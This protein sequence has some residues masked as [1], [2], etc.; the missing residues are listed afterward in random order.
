MRTIVAQATI[1]TT[2]FL[3]A[4]SAGKSCWIVLF[5]A[6]T[7][8]HYNDQD[9]ERSSTMGKRKATKPPPASSRKK[10]APTEE[11]KVPT[12][13]TP[14]EE[15]K[16]MDEECDNAAKSEA[17][18][19]KKAKE[20]PIDGKINVKK[21][22]GEG[23]S[24]VLTITLLKDFEGSGES[25]EEFDLLGL[26][27][28]SEDIYGGPASHTRRLVQKCWQ[29]L[30]EKSI[31]SYYNYL[32][33]H[34]VIPGQE[35]ATEYFAVLANKVKDGDCKMSDD[36]SDDDNSSYVSETESGDETEDSTP[37]KPTFS[38]PFS[39][40]SDPKGAKYSKSSSKKA[41]SSSKSASSSKKSKS[42]KKTKSS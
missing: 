19:K 3:L 14:L 13:T 25:R 23:L 30:K 7:L 29:K 18:K 38:S 36:N 28:N 40:P 32:K 4:G 8:I 24:R 10:K 42:S 35:T 41:K 1:L 27:N 17:A 26:C 22:K 39:S 21:S 15:D 9:K 37:K 20:L 11:R 31:K 2:R 34:N 16:K 12:D 33:K 5:L 6:P